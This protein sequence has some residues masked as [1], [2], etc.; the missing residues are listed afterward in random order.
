MQ[1]AIILV[2]LGS[3]DKRKVLC[4]FRVKQGKISVLQKYQYQ[5]D[6]GFPISILIC[7]LLNAQKCNSDLKEQE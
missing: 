5:K 4:V 1:I 3:R 7:S 6:K 2:C